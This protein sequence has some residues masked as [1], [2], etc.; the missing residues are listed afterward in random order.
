MPLKR[1]IKSYLFG[2][3][4]I[5]LIIELEFDAGMVSGYVSI[6]RP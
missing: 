1:I 2:Q 4:Y 5:K 6:S 3:K